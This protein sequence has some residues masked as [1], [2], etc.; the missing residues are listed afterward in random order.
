MASAREQGGDDG[1]NSITIPLLGDEKAEQRSFYN[2]DQLPKSA[3]D[4][5]SVHVGNTSFFKTCFHGINAIS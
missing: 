5:D 3:D 2:G 1:K 4:L